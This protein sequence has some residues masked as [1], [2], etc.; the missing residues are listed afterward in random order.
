MPDMD[1]NHIQLPTAVITELYSNVIV[2]P[3]TNTPVN[4]INKPDK[5]ITKTDP[6]IPVT[7][8]KSLGTNEKNI[9]IVVNN[10]DAVYLPDKDLIFLTGVLGACN[11]SLADVAVINLYNYPD[12]GYKE[13]TGYFNSRIILLFGTE[14]AGFG[15]PLNFPR[16]QVQEFNGKKYLHCP[17]L[18]EIEKDRVEKSKL[19]VCLKTLFN[20]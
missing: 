13:L 1:L 11:L 4:D 3:V 7:D 5:R 16:Y 20:I 19:W 18:N 15:L 8:W 2:E 9:L 14:P 12:A 17:I 6:E 10:P